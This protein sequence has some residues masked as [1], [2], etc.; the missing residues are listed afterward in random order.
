MNHSVFENENILLFTAVSNDECQRGSCPTAEI[1]VP[2][3][4]AALAR[5]AGDV[6]RRKDF[7]LKR[8]SGQ[9]C[10]DGGDGIISKMHDINP[11]HP[12]LFRLPSGCF[13]GAHQV[14]FEHL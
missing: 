4:P 2:L 5:K 9:H 10:K 8:S 3:A 1:P 14:R 12:T 11:Q 7:I 6:F 13:L